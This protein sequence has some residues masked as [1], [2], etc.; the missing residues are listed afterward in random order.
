[1]TNKDFKSQLDIE[2]PSRP[3]SEASSD[4]EIEDELQVILVQQE[5]EAAEA[6]RQG[7]LRTGRTAH[8]VNPP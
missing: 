2:T 6:A 7:V 5:E 3:V 8:A 1:M 4:V